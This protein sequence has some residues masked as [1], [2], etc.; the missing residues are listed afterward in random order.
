MYAWIGRNL[1]ENFFKGMPTLSH[2][3][4]M[5]SR[6]IPCLCYGFMYHPCP[7]GDGS[8]ELYKLSNRL[9]VFVLKNFLDLKLLIGLR[10]NFFDHGTVVF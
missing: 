5:V 2:A 9:K 7:Y 3:Y 8:R 10:Q 1:R 4:A 6:T